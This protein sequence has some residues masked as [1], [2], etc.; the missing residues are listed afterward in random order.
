MNEYIGQWFEIIDGMSNCNTYK[1]AFGKGII[2]CIYNRK[3]TYN[4]LNLVVVDFKDIAECMIRYYWNQSFFFHLKQQPGNRVPT[5]YQHVN[6]LIEKY[7]ILSGTNIP[8][9]SD[10]GL[11]LIKKEAP[12][13]YIYEVEQVAKDLNKDVCWRFPHLSSGDK[14][15]Y[16][17]KKELGS[18]LFFDPAVIEDIREH[19]FVLSRLLNYRWSMLLEKFNVTPNI[20]NKVNDAGNEKIRR[21]SLLKYRKILEM[22]F[23]EG[24][25]EDFYSNDIILENEISVDHVIPWSFIYRDDIWNLVLTSKSNNSSKSNS[26]PTEN[27][28]RKL[29]KRNEKLYDILP[30]GPMK[31][32]LDEAIHN[33]LVSKYYFELI[34]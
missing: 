16:I 4:S 13:F 32:S 27:I 21:N 34:A 6:E 11:G 26:A 3:F 15:L 10:E 7:K 18:F 14:N 17:Y 24:Q 30:S 2:E 1:P 23:P 25:A 5:I 9:W 28:I 8:C 31:D 12:K 20:L 22:E 19:A 33:N 29:E